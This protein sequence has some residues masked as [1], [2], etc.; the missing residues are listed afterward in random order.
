MLSQAL[1]LLLLREAVTAATVSV[2][3]YSTL[4]AT[5]AGPPVPSPPAYR[6]EDFG[7]GA[8]MVTD[9]LYQGA[10]FVTDD[11][12]VA[13]DAPPT[14]GHNLV[15]AIRSVT[16]N[17]VSHV[18]Y[19]HHHA[20][21]IGGAYLYNGPNVTFVAHQLTEESLA[22]HPE[23]TRPMPNITFETNYTLTVGNLTLELAYHGDNH[24]PGNIYVY[25]PGQKVLI[26]VDVVYPGWIPF[27]A[28]GLAQSVPGYI[29]AHDDLLTYDFDHY[30]G[31]HLDRSGTRD[32]VMVAR[33]Y[34]HDLFNTSLQAIQLSAAPDGNLSFSATLLPAET[35][36]N[37]NNGWAL[38][39]TYIDI[40][41]EWV[42]N[43]LATRWADK[44][45]ATDVYG[46][47]HV[48][49]MLE[50]VRIDFGTL[51]PFGVPAE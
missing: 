7:G 3:S 24:A 49:V 14:I 38:F 50:S 48:A 39:D 1:V 10:F 23:Y 40:L 18:V 35:I 13:V 16:S 46:R 19:T 42:Y 5:A 41:T 31:G 21:H 2:E 8:Y 4:P 26:L 20:D 45:Y 12:V 27:N 33:E 6:L 44:L 15:D 37:P 29:K 25:A 36:Q 47:S 11:S 30:I 34:L 22:Y 9:G 43:E 51:G 28:L 32:D 17:A